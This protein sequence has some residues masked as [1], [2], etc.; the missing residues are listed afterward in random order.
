MEPKTISV[1]ESILR[2]LMR[3]KRPTENVSDLIGRLV[4]QDAKHSEYA[5]QHENLSRLVKLYLP[6]SVIAEFLS[7]KAS[8]LHRENRILTVMFSDIR[9][10]TGISEAMTPECSPPIALSAF[11]P[12]LPE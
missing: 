12:N 7:R 5:E 3:I 1:N 11:F 4:D 2:A 9:S 10:F 6:E 8:L